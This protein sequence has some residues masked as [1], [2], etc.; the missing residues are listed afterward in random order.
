[1]YAYIYT[2]VWDHFLDHG[3]PLRA[4]IAPPVAWIAAVSSDRFEI[5]IASPLI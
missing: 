4:L 5:S 3:Q 2:G 1:M